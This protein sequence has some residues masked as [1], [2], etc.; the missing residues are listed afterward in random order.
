MVGL[1]YEKFDSSVVIKNF[2]DETIFFIEPLGFDVKIQYRD[3]IQ[4]FVFPESDVSDWE[5]RLENGVLYVYVP[6]PYE[7]LDIYKNGVYTESV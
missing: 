2:G 4:L 5:I 7:R 6:F 3:T 1:E